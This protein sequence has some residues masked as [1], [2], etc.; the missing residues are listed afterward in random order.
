MLKQTYPC[1]LRNVQNMSPY[2]KLRSYQ[3]EWNKKKL[4]QILCKNI[5]FILVHF[6]V[7]L[8]EFVTYVCILFISY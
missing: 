7:L 6:L 4:R 3:G 8:C 2:A 5:I 1:S